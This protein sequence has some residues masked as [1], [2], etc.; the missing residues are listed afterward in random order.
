MPSVTDLLVE[1]GLPAFGFGTW[2]AGYAAART[3]T[4]PTGVT[5]APAAP[6]LGPHTPAVVS[7]FANRWEF[8]EDAAEATLLD[9][10]AR[11]YLEFR[12]GGADPRHT[13]VHLTA[14]APDD[15]RPYERQV[16]DRVVERATGGVV[17]LTALTFTNAGLAV[18]WS[19][20]LRVAVIA[21]ARA[22]GLSRRRYSVAWVGLLTVLAV[23]A[24]LSA[25]VAIAHHDGDYGAAAGGAIVAAGLLITA[26]G[27]LGGERDTPAGR[28][29]AATWLGVRDWLSAHP[30]FANLPPSAV[31]TWDRYMSYGAALGTTR[32]A[33]QIIELGLADRRRIWSSY[34]GHWR[35]VTIRYPSLPKNGSHWGYLLLRA[36]IT[37]MV[38]WTF[39]TPSR[40]YH[41]LFEAN[42][43]TVAFTLLGLFLLAWGAYLVVRVVM[44]LASPATV[45]GQVLW[46]QVWKERNNDNG[47]NIPTLY[48]LA[49]D[50]GTQDRT[51]AWVSP[52]TFADGCRAGDE[53][54]LT[55]RP[56]TRWVTALEPVRRGP[57]WEAWAGEQARGTLE[58]DTETLLAM[59][60][61]LGLARPG[62]L[63][64]AQEVGRALG[65]RE[66]TAFTGPSV[67]GATATAGYDSGG[68]R[69]LEIEV[70]GAQQAT[71]I[72]DGR[73]SAGTALPN[74][75]D[76]AYTGADWAA[77]R[78]GDLLVMLRLGPGAAGADPRFLPWLLHT[79]IGR[80]PVEVDQAH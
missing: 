10:G 52:A 72:L 37:L 67:G 47:P 54:R 68:Q 71:R 39:T 27:R 4:R 9:L 65:G 15:L 2:F 61:A 8:T 57:E 25:A 7:L 78:R 60:P 20:R 53:V 58:H 43:V 75:G 50:E 6:D 70:S 1:L 44:D 63:L 11:R 46:I 45:T 42:L 24:G 73:R 40:L 38:G 5:P 56:W 12:Q 55:V 19:K 79:A 22:E 36:A 66:L 51:V 29:A 13:T 64:T 32:V 3:L 28:A 48:Y 35:R 21:Q 23:I 62:D 26:A 41:R 77:A 76:E 74:I 16:Y 30:E 14:K 34:G 80:L 31:A 17:P 49:V 18:A 59:A 33:S 69:A